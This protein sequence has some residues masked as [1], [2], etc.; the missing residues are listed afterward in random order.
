M[1]LK[2]SDGLPAENV[3][4]RIDENVLIFQPLSN[5]YDNSSVTDAAEILRGTIAC[6]TH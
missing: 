5:V 6:F 1:F 2:T 4:S 3:T